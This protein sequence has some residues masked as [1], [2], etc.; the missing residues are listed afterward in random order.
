MKP[1]RHPPAIAADICCIS[2]IP[3]YCCCIPLHS[4]S[5]PNCPGA[6]KD[7][8][9]AESEGARLQDT[10]VL[11]K[12]EEAKG[13]PQ[14]AQASVLCGCHPMTHLDCLS[15]EPIQNCGVQARQFGL[16]KNT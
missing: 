15:K 7:P 9:P 12:L 8:T 13:Q 16:A 2:I 11:K 10:I 14:E 4:K 6:S 1:S 5:F 3:C